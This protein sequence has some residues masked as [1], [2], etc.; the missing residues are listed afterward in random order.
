M[1][2]TIRIG[3]GHYVEVCMGKATVYV[4]THVG[5]TASDV[6]YGIGAFLGNFSTLKAAREYA[7]GPKRRRRP[8]SE[9]GTIL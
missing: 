9:P 4:H 6:T 1:T 3:P 8:V 5:W 7:H 2:R